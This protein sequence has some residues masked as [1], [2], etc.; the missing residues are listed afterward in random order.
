MLGCYMHVNTCVCTNTYMYTNNIYIKKQY[1]IYLAWSVY[2]DPT[3]RRYTSHIHMLIEL[4]QLWR[5][6][7]KHSQ[8]YIPNKKHYYL[9]LNE[10]VFLKEMKWRKAPKVQTTRACPACSSWEIKGIAKVQMG[11]HYKFMLSECHLSQASRRLAR[12]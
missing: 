8:L 1:Y 9:C 6:V 5:P 12:F 10:L 11:R 4:E 3:A 2:Y 7:R